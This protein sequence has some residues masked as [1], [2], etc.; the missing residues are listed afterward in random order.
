MGPFVISTF[1]LPTNSLRI[2]PGLLWP[3]LPR[4]SASDRC[5][6]QRHGVAANDSRRSRVREKHDCVLHRFDA[7]HG[8]VPS[9]ESH[10]ASARWHA[11]LSSGCESL[12]TLTAAK[13]NTDFTYT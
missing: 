2:P 8:Y 12:N 11:V 7:D 10:A 1:K 4:A 9:G 5:R 13:R 3:C 6:E